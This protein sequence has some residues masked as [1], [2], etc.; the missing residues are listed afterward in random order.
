[1]S[2]Q[3]KRERDQTAVVNIANCRDC[4]WFEFCG[5][6]YTKADNMA[7]DH[8]SYREHD[9]GVLKETLELPRNHEGQ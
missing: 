7:Y 5:S 9:A 6:D 3:D 8:G 2:E 1:M 4:D